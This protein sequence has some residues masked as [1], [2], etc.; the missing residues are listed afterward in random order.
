MWSLTMYWIYGKRNKSNQ[1][2]SSEH[3][4]VDEIGYFQ[5][6]NISKIHLQEA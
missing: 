1:I 3:L 4:A 5:G 2:K 6:K